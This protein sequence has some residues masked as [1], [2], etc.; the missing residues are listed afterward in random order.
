MEA[1]DTPIKDATTLL[2]GSY[3]S[4]AVVDLPD[5]FIQVTCSLSVSQVFELNN[6]LFSFFLFLLRGD[7]CTAPHVGA[8]DASG[9]FHVT[10][11]SVWLPHVAQGTHVGAEM[12]VRAGVVGKDDK[13]I[14]NS[15]RLGLQQ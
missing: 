2:L 12:G 10:L 7:V 6:F 4:A 15:V 3:P 14:L 9:H 1:G 8:V 5:F 13:C 11:G